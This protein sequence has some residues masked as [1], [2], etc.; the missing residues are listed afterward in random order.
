M[1]EVERLL[2][3]SSVRIE[4][5]DPRHPDARFCFTTYFADLAGRFDTGYNPDEAL[6]VDD[7]EVT[8][9]AGVVL[10]A[11]LYAA[12]VGCVC[13]K[14]RG[15]APASAAASWPRSSRTPWRRACGRYAWTPT[16]R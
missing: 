5:R 15:D 6:P 3:A 8:P 4:P 9:P 16:G 10:V 7:D 2:L 11:T 12:P 13:L 1:A 14:R